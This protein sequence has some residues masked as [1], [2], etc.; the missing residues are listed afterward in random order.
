MQRGCLPQARRSLPVLS[1]YASAGH[2]HN[3][4]AFKAAQAKLGAQGLPGNSAGCLGLR[5]RC[6]GDT[7][8]SAVGL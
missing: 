7:A 1:S 5:G 6:P 3:D 8:E 2:F 4:F